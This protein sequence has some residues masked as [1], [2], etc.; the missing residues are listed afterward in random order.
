MALRDEWFGKD[1]ISELIRSKLGIFT[2]TEMAEA[3]QPE[4][5]PSGQEPD[6]VLKTLIEMEYKRYQTLTGEDLRLY[7]RMVEV[8][9]EWGGNF[10]ETQR[11]I[12]SFHEKLSLNATSAADELAPC[13][14]LFEQS[15]SQSRKTRAG[16]SLELQLEYILRK[17]GITKWEKQKKLTMPGGRTTKV[18]FLFPSVEHF[19]NDPLD[20]IAFCCQTTS[21]DRFRSAL[22]QVKLG[23]KFI[24]TGIGSS[25]FGSNL[26]KLTLPKLEEVQNSGAKYVMFPEGKNFDEVMSAHSAIITYSEL[27]QRIK[28]RHDAWPSY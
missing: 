27:I 2:V 18:D 6:Q 12:D 22:G 15:Q 10:P 23:M 7:S 26:Q 16:S 13:A 11:L 24:P 5:Y 25:N 20:C 1:G 9:L 21:N 17:N 3:V 8:L 14:F 19:E 4:E 28:E